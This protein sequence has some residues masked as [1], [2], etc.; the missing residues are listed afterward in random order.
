MI[1]LHDYQVEGKKQ[2]AGSVKR[3]N[4]RVIY[5]LST[6]GGK[7]VVMSAVG[8][9]YIANSGKSV[10]VIVHRDELL[11]QMR[12]TVFDFDGTM[13]FPIIAGL[14]HIPKSKMYV[15]MVETINN[16]LRKFPSLMEDVGM[17]IYDE[18]HRG[19]M[20]KIQ[21]FFP[22]AIMIGFTATPES[23]SLKDPLKNYFD[24]IVC[25]PPIAELIKR[26]ALVQNITHH[27]KGGVNRK[28]LKV[29]STGDFATADMGKSFSTTRHITNTVEA[30]K[31]YADG[32]KAIVYN[33]NIEH[34]TIVN[35]A[36]LDAGYPSRHVDSKLCEKDA[37][38]RKDV[39]DWFAAT[40][41]AVLNNI[42]I[43]TTGFNSRDVGC[44]IVNRATMSRVLWIQM[45]GRG[46]RTFPGKEFFIIL[47]MGSNGL[48]HGD[49]S[50]H[51]DWRDAF[52]NPRKPKKDGVA[53]VKVCPN[54]ACEC[55]IAAQATVC[56]FCG[57]EMPRE[58]KPIEDALPVEM[59]IL[60][61]NINVTE[62]IEKNK[63]HK[64]YYPFFLIGNNL[65][66]QARKTV[67]KGEMTTGLAGKIMDEYHRL[68]KE[69][70]RAHEKRYSAWHKTTA[71]QH[72]FKQL[73]TYYPDVNLPIPEN[74]PN[75]R[76]G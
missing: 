40:P 59:E 67:K 74:Q 48:T 63:Q 52:F 24:D 58:E 73:N 21:Q 56:K 53:P 12:R 29:A 37:S 20:K 34:S 23:S 3:G 54:P 47:D 14:K 38:Y 36:F 13:S 65:A 25:G 61:K 31:K 60:T 69:W 76:R 22:N 27:I 32:A 46:G 68:A 62:L 28:D 10:L 4:R 66:S 33:C 41:G 64:E 35:Q 57:T 50:D 18:I 6:G 75:D 17:V 11:N 72:L 1:T 19:E 49:W 26:G 2:L 42:D 5:Q 44:I 8:S 45:C 16:W 55:L 43:L 71:I 7:S 70:C 30:Y 51:I 39:L 15:A 9:G